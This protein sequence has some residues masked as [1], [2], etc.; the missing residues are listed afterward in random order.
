MNE[1]ID[2]NIIP[3]IGEDLRLK[4]LRVIHWSRGGHLK[5]VTPFINDFKINEEKIGK[6]IGDMV[7]AGCQLEMVV[8]GFNRYD[9]PHIDHTGSDFDCTRCRNAAF[10]ISLLNYY[11]KIGA[12]IIIKDELHAKIYLSQGFNGNKICLTGSPNLTDTG[13]SKR[14]ELGLY[15]VNQQIINQIEGFIRVWENSTAYGGKAQP[16]H[17]WR[18]ELLKKSMSFRKMIR[19]YNPLRN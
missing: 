2:N 8:A 18:T 19:D 13:F 11:E 17:I 14:C 1:L 16:F 12:Q 10:K 6:R 3:C 9:E 7:R 4:L 5:I 15:I